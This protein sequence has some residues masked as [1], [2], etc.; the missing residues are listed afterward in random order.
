MLVDTNVPELTDEQIVEI[1]AWVDPATI[2]AEFIHLAKLV[3]PAGQ[4][5]YLDGA[6]YR[7]F[8]DSHPKG[9]FIGNVELALDLDRF[10][11]NVL[12]HTQLVL[13]KEQVNDDYFCFNSGK[14]T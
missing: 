3:T 5:L 12:E 13:S 7:H 11:R 6:E 10:G 4:I 2:P 9:S 8:V 14:Q 1:F